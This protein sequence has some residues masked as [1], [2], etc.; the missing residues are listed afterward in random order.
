LAPLL[1]SHI[2]NTGIHNLSNYPLSE[3]EILALSLGQTFIPTP[4]AMKDLPS[5]IDEQFADYR[6]RC[7]V[8]CYFHEH[9]SSMETDPKLRIK[10]SNWN[11][12]L[13]S[14]HILFQY[15]NQ[16][17]AKL[18]RSVQEV[19]RRF[20]KHDQTSQ[21]TPPWIHSTLLNLKNNKDIIITDADKNMGICVISTKQYVEEGLRQLNDDKTYRALSKPPDIDT[22]RADLES[23]LKRHNRFTGPKRFANS[24]PVLSDLAKFCLQ[25]L[26]STLHSKTPS[27]NEKLR[28]GHF[29]LLMK[30]HKEKVTGRPIV[31]SYDTC[32]YHVSRYID[33]ILQPLLKR[34]FSYVQSSEHL[35]HLLERT[36]V[37]VDCRDKS[38]MLCADIESLYPNIPLDEGLKLFKSSIEF[39]NKKLKK[40]ERLSDSDIALVCDLTEWVLHNNYFTFG[41][42]IYHQINGTAMGTPCAVVFACLF[43]DALERDII[44]KHKLTPILYRRYIDDIFAIFAERAQ[45]E[46]FI[47]KFNSVFDT[48]KC[49]ASSTTISPDQGVFLDAEVYRPTSFVEFGRFHTRLFQKKQNKYLYIPPFSY[50]SK[51]M[52]PAFIKAEI[53]RYRLLCTDDH[54]FNTACKQFETRL[55]DRGYSPSFLKPL[56]LSLPDRQSL[57]NNVSSRFSPNLPAGKQSNTPCPFI[58]KVIGSP[59]TKLLNIARCLCPSEDLKEHPALTPLFQRKPLVSYSNA[60]SIST[61]FSRARKSLHSY[62]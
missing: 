21:K 32:T 43:I 26:G 13:S 37:P 9:P 12:P 54:D 11:P 15:M 36:E 14:N 49:G 56:F 1:P 3:K 2:S 16:V 35:I 20:E 33:S 57:L 4:R 41:D 45:A 39:N 51:S 7:S 17:E 59:Q 52:F 50:H 48:I 31:S 34:A 22:I 46:T 19:Q 60:P 18:D 28:L 10:G 5:Y 53:N 40:T 25:D 29:Y 6:R 58:F 47:K 24:K 42:K 44:N 38:V 27:C 8:A 55:K 30:V 61:Y 62:L 23:I